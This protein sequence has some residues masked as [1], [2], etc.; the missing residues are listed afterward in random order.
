MGNLFR[1]TD[2][3]IIMS[4]LFPAICAEASVVTGRRQGLRRRVVR[5]AGGGCGA[6]E[7][8]CAVDNNCRISNRLSLT[9]SLTSGVASCRSRCPPQF[10]S[11]ECPFCGKACF[12][13]TARS[14]LCLRRGCAR[15]AIRHRDTEPRPSFLTPAGG[16]WIPLSAECFGATTTGCG[17]SVTGRRSRVIHL[18]G[19]SGSAPP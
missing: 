19:Q 11:N 13:R 6:V 1:P 12:L 7:G 14:K 17:Y 16:S 2:R 10:V 4:L 3:R 9:D 15:A 8:P 5:A 18:D